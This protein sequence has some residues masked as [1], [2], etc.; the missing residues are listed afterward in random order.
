MNIKLLNNEEVR[1]YSRR[2]WQLLLIDIVIWLVLSALPWYLYG[3]FSINYRSYVQVYLIL[4]GIF[5]ITR[6]VA[7]IRTVLVITNQRIIYSL[8]HG[9]LFSKR[10]ESLI[11]QINHVNVE[12]TWRL[13][14]RVRLH[15]ASGALILEFEGF[16]QTDIIKDLLWHLNKHDEGS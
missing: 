10:T 14:Q 12:R 4:V 9:T 7:Y 1:Y 2:A 5:F 11:G 3:E 16:P 15:S 6:L 13:L 8:N